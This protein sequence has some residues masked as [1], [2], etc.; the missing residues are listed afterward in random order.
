MTGGKC[1]APPGPK[2]LPCLASS[3][4]PSNSQFSDVPSSFSPFLIWHFC[5]H[6]VW[7]N[8]FDFWA[9]GARRRWNVLEILRACM[10][11]VSWRGL[12]ETDQAAAK[13]MKQYVYMYT[14]FGVH[15]AVS[16][17]RGFFWPL[18]WMKLGWGWEEGEVKAIRKFHRL[19]LS[20]YYII[21]QS[22]ICDINIFIYLFIYLFIIINR[23]FWFA[24]DITKYD[25][26]MYIYNW[27]FRL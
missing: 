10:Q 19:R 21:L 23:T 6:W 17:S 18:H 2:I 25:T 1:I 14:I 26:Q 15:H 11:W 4:G 27:S 5:W 13:A 20:V 12:H 9:K 3:I 7:G 22:P 24:S 16:H 8:Y